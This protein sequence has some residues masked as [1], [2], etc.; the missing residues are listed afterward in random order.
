MKRLIKDSTLDNVADAIREKTGETATMT[1]VQMPDKIRGIQAG[2]GSGVD[3]SDATFTESDLVKGKIAY[4]NGV[5][6]IGTLEKI[7]HIIGVDANPIIDE[8]YLVASTI[9]AE[10][11][12]VD[13]QTEIDVKI[14]SSIFGDATPEDVAEGKTFTSFDA[15]L[16]AV[17]TGKMS[18]EVVVVD[19]PNNVFEVRYTYRDDVSFKLVLKDKT[20]LYI[21]F[22]ML[23]YKYADTPLALQLP[24]NNDYMQSD[25]VTFSYSSEAGSGQATINADFELSNFFKSIQVVYKKT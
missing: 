6:I 4:G 24:Y 20:L 21:P 14:H 3:T 2:G 8:G 18:D 19:R 17:G 5:K 10:K 13:S 11:G 7:D 22:K 1:P 25:P 16:C 15:G 23:R 9:P 12:W